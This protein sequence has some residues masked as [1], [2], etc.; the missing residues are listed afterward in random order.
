MRRPVYLF[1]GLRYLRASRGSGFVSFVTVASVLGVALGVATLIVVLSVMNGFETELRDRLLGLTSHAAVVADEPLQQWRELTAALDSQPGIAGAAPYV[2]LEAMLSGAGAMT[3]GLVTGVQPDLEVRVSK[4]A[5]SMLAGSLAELTPRGRGIV[6]GRAL[7]Q[8]LGVALGD[9]VTVLVPRP[10]RNGGGVGSVTDSFTVVGLFELGVQDHDSVRAMLYLEDAAALGG[11]SGAV[12]GV[13]VETENIFSAPRVVR[14]AVAALVDQPDL[15]VRDW[16]QE[17]ASYFRA[18]RIEK[19]MMM[20]LLSLIIGVAAF[21]IVAMLVMV[22]TE[23]RGGIAILRTLGCTRGDIVAVFVLQGTVIGWAG[24]LLGLV[25]GV[26]MALN[27]DTLAPALETLFGF[28]FMPADLYY[29]T[30]LPTELQWGDVVG[31]SAIVLLVT[32]LATIYPAARAASV[33]PA[34]VLRYE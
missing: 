8:K 27:V 4:V 23:K 33:Q 15:T 5:N 22:V 32:T 13:R 20:L 25:L 19:I 16:T 26:W 21:N 2:E 11:L 10:P 3:A 30:E 18:I 9:R 34:E 6:L 7:A 28:S 1:V 24:A 14:A 31:T 17:N 29:L 12:T